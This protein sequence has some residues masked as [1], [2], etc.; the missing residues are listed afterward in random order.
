MTTDENKMKN[1][2]SLIN[3]FADFLDI[4]SQRKL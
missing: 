3:C 1:E 4:Q 2:R